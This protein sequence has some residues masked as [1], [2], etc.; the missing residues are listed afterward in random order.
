M[1][2]D[3]KELSVLTIA[4]TYIGTVVGAGFA[5]GQEVFQFFTLYG[6]WGAIGIVFS[7]GLFIFFGYQIMTM[8]SDLKAESHLKIIR[9][10]GG[11]II[12]TFI[13]WVITAFLFGA[14]VIMAAGAGAIFKE[15]FNQPSI[16]GSGIMVIATL[17]TVIL[18]LKNII[19]A[20]SYVVPFLL[21]AV[22]SVALITIFSNPITAEKISYVKIAPKVAAPNWLIAAILY[23]S[24]NMILAVAVLAP[25]GV[26]AENKVKLLK[27]AILG[28]VGLGAG[29][30][31]INL[32]MLAN[33]PK[34]A[35]FEVPMVFLA[36]K[37]SPVF[38]LGYS[39][40]LIME[41]YTTA[42]GSLY[43]FVVRLVEQ[44]GRTQKLL[45]IVAS[46]GA[47]FGAQLGFSTMV[48]IVFPIVGYAGLFL[49]GGITLVTFKKYFKMYQQDFVYAK[50]VV[51]KEKE[52]PETSDK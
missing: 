19:K 9:H 39:V 40:V 32:A 38:T 27:G 31:A 5:T 35:T 13:D 18:G 29:A 45:A 4:A 34:T 47:F 21:I 14:V 42:V 49:L 36:S 8:A 1:I 2:K 52:N 25:L 37:L 33:I 48:K 26:L 50:P 3:G 20:I 41:V 24:Y 44:E 51:K 7:T 30:L 10:A 28:G 16:L 46:G 17:I 6:W 12:G 22:L 43:G 15:Q 23:V 11:K